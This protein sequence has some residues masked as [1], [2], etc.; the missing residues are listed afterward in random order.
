MINL[1][2]VLLTCLCIPLSLEA[3][4]EKSSGVIFDGSSVDQL[5]LYEWEYDGRILRGRGKLHIHN[6]KK[7]ANYE[8]RIRLRYLKEFSDLHLCEV[9]VPEANPSKNVLNNL[10]GQW[11]DIRIVVRNM[12][13]EQ[14][15]IKN[16]TPLGNGEAVVYLGKDVRLSSDHIPRN[17]KMTKDG[18]VEG[19]AER[20]NF[21]L[22]NPTEISKIEI[23]PLSPDSPRE[24]LD[25]SVE[26]LKKAVTAGAAI[27]K[28]N[29]FNCHGDGIGKPPNPLARSFT[30]DRLLNGADL[31]SMFETLTTGFR[32]MPPMAS[33]SV[34]QRLHVL[35]YVREKIF[36]PH[37]PKNRVDVT[38]KAID[39]LPYSLYSTEEN[40][41]RPKDSGGSDLAFKEGRYRDHGPAMI[42]AN[43]K[44]RNAMQ[45]KLPGKTT[46]SYN[47]NAMESLGVWHG[48]F[49]E[50]MKSHYYEGHGKVN[51]VPNGTMVPELG[52]WRWAH[53]G[54]LDYPR[55]APTGPL[56]FDGFRWNGHYL[57]D[58]QA[59]LSYSIDARNI[60]ESP[61][62]ILDKKGTR[63]L[64]Q[65]LKIQPG[66]ELLL[67]VGHAADCRA[68]PIVEAPM[69][70]GKMAI[71]IH[72]DR[73]GLT[74]KIDKGWLAIHI[75]AGQ[76]ARSFSVIRSVG[77]G[78]SGR[79]SAVNQSLVPAHFEILT[80]GGERRWT[81]EYNVTGQLSDDKD[82]SYVLDTIPVPFENAYNSWMRTTSL[83]F[84]DDGRA[85]VTTYDGDVWIVSGI[86]DALGKVTWSRFAAGIHET[87]GCQVVDGKVLVTTR[88]GIVRLHDY[89]NDGEA[90]FYEQFFTD[91]DFSLIYH[92]Y[93]FDLVR[94]DDGYLYYSKNGQYT[95][96]TFS[97]GC[98]K[99]SPDGKSF[100]MH[101]TGFRTPNG[102][103]IL[104]GGRILMADNQGGWV[105][106]GKISI[107]EPGKWYGGSGRQG[108]F[109]KRK[110]FAQPIL[111]L[112]QD[113]DSSCGGQVWVDD[114]RFGPYGNGALFH[115]S[116]GL[117]KAMMVFVDD[118]AEPTQA[119]TQVFPFNF[120]S[121][122]MRPRV[123]PQDGQVYVTGTRGWGVFAP[124][125]G[126]LQR[127]RYTGK[128]EPMVT[129]VKAR[130][131]YIELTFNQKV[132]IDAK[133]CQV[134][135]WNY[136]WSSQYGSP[137]FSVRKP[138]VKSPDKVEVTGVQVKENVIRVSVPSLLP[139]HQ[140]KLTYRLQGKDNDQSVH[141]TIH[142]L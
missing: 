142:S 137:K 69:Q 75:P 7:Y 121:G 4:E 83:A 46:I 111:W 109:K 39:A 97:G 112:P 66:K 38:P 119:S 58:D 88:S 17:L 10:V 35:H 105:P 11:R 8:L 22:R 20:I 31:L 70:C 67:G 89:N 42:C 63:T 122:I 101:G 26:D 53:G 110:T 138:G 12:K 45:V 85:V 94:D 124:D 34:E 1:A 59:V 135:M 117:A 56:T 21:F 103:G 82:S 24:Y 78:A 106:A 77:D 95:D 115:T 49:M 96:I 16:M 139:A 134:S 98:Y 133:S 107:I 30:Q 28:T 76:N 2:C 141:L 127:V 44:E 100:T 33:L 41:K 118:D 36:K 80:Q 87:F 51:P 116:C 52:K 84:F 72:G 129:D 92:G 136:L 71:A 120:A 130:K 126:C 50:M 99:I 27:Y 13:A 91:P 81:T 60:L 48:G 131:G 18:Y 74:W 47:L 9:I 54:N 23:L 128:Q 114:R 32:Y 29:C 132:R 40:A 37:N 15:R 64:V 73:R 79:V 108:E 123:N 90:D 25:L 61:D 125:D 14:K 68:G 6:K 19:N 93:N 62:C 102:M 65:H 43:G 113:V 55:N 3:K 57:Y 5:K 86:D 104:P 140:V